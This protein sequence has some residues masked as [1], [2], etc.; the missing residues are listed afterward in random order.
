MKSTYRSFRRSLMGWRS[1]MAI[2]LAIGLVI[3]TLVYGETWTDST[4][5]FKIDAE[6]VSLSG[7]T[8]TLKKPDGKTLQV[9]LT[10]LD[11][12]GQELAKR[13]ASGT[14][15]MP[16]SGNSA[17]P[18]AYL[19]DLL[20]AA[21]AGDSQRLWGALPPS[22]QQDLHDVIHSFAT[23]MDPQLW[24][25]VTGVLKKA[26]RVLNEKQSF[27]LGLPQA[28]AAGPVL[29]KTL[30]PLAGLVESIVQSE[31]TDLKQLKTIDLPKFAAGS[32]KKITE[33]A[34]AFQ[35]VAEDL[36]ALA[37]GGLPAGA[38][39][40]NPFAELSRIKPTDIQV[41]LVSRSGASAVLKIEVPGKPS[42]ESEWQLLDG[43]WLPKEMVDDWKPGIEKAKEWTA[44]EMKQKLQEVKGQ[45]GF[46]IAPVN[47]TL[48]Q[49]LAA[50]TQEQF[51]QVI[52]NLQQQFRGAPP[53]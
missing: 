19:R 25:Q 35:A 6:F 47:L 15:P 13:L 50:Q 40:G 26:S 12:A 18:D 5:K 31:L 23:N 17:E 38:G 16:Q 33:K 34:Q 4:G 37:P 24:N 22:Y 11:A 44:G 20:K 10:R 21:E 27:I 52:T 46:F 53:K 32:G 30:P 42:R 9:P 7:Q 2:V 43:K 28:A 49:L 51:N 14:K 1:W 8:V 3:P 45:V 36:K 41:T 39:E 29:Q 48:D